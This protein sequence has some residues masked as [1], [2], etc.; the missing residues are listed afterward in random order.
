MKYEGHLGR[1]HLKG[2]H[3]DLTAV[4]HNFCLILRWLRLLLRLIQNA[5]LEKFSA[6]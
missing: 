3:G 6:N 4:G 1:N 5:I 2:R